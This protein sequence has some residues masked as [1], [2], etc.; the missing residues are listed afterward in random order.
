MGKRDNEKTDR[1]TAYALEGMAAL[2]GFL[3]TVLFLS[4]VSMSALPPKADMCSAQAD[5]R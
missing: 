1:H 4:G 2:T 3:F 5:V